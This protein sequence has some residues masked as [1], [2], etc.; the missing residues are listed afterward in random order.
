MRFGFVGPAYLSA[1]PLAAAE[2]LINWRP[3]KVESP[4]ARTA[5]LLLPSSGLSLFATL[6]A[7]LPSVRGEWTGNGRAF[8]VA[9]THLYELNALGGVTDYGGTGTANNNIVDDGLP[10]T[11]VA[12]GTVGAV[13]LGNPQG[14]TSAVISSAIAAAI[15]VSSGVSFT[16]GASAVIAGI[17][18]PAFGQLNG[19]WVVASIVG[20]TVNLTTSGLTVE[21]TTALSAGTATPSSTAPGTY[22]SQLLICS[23]GN[24]TV[25]SLSS[26]AFQPLTTPPENNLMV[27]FMD[28]YFIALQA[29]N[30]FSISNPEDA[31]TWPGLSISQVQVFSDQ[32]LS[33]IVANRLLCVFGSKRAV[34]Y[35]TSGAPIFPLDVASG[36]FME[37]GIAAQF[38]AARIATHQGTTILWLGGD[39]RGQGVVYA[40][41]GFTPQRVSDSSLEYW[42]SQQTTI[43][44]AVGMARQE[45][46]QNFYDLW[47]PSANATWTLDIDLGWWHRRSSLVN[48]IESA[49]LQRSHM[50]AFGYHLIGDRTSGNVYRLSSSFPTDNGIPILR[51]RVGPTIENEGGQITVPINEFQVDFETG[52]GPIPPLT[53]GFGNPRDPYAMF[54]YSE[55]Y[56]K[57][58]TP[59]RQ[60]ACGQAGEFKVVAIDRRLGSW[61]SWT[62]RVRVSDPIQWRIA[63]AYV[64]GTQDQKKRLAK[65]F[66]EIG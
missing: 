30:S 6:A 53:D 55:D 42:M 8:C 36:G 40:A 37:V 13:N 35:Y 17:T 33:I 43:S 50:N 29:T 56:G 16:V 18:S 66:A 2:Q 27:D 7:G 31:T 21:A 59:E 46:G 14:I 57:T 47:F 45:E 41:N 58:W 61:R 49:H 34:F 32:L 52:L 62:P 63:D 51:T 4:N 64:N 24:L 38:S 26:N 1:S 3:Q 60:I 54:S 23:G 5:Y 20:T 22:P 28:G 11:I 19:T 44:D 65:T 48:G 25:F 9:G 10:A 39:E 12:G 15:T